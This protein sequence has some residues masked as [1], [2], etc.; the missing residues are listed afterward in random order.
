MKYKQDCLYFI[1]DRPCRFHKENP[2]IICERCKLYSP[3]NQKILIIKLAAIGDVVRTLC[4][5]KPLYKRYKN[6]RIFWITNDDAVDVLKNNPYIYEIVPYS[7][8]FYLFNQNFDILINLDLDQTAL[9]LT[10]QIFSKEKFGFYLS[11][12]DKIICSNTQAEYWFDLSHNDILKKKNRK[13][14]Q[15]CML[16]ILGFENLKL[17]DYPIILNLTEEEKKFAEDFYKKNISQAKKNLL[18]IGVNLGGGDKWRKKE[19]PIEKTIQLIKLIFKNEKKFNK[20]IKVILFGGLKER[21]RN[22]NILSELKEYVLD[23]K[24]IDAGCEN[25]LREFFSLVNLCDVFITSDSLGLHVVLG[26]NKKVLVLF[27]P[28]SPF[29]IELYGLGEKIITPLKC[30]SCYKRSCSK[31]PDCMDTILPEYIFA[32]LLKLVKK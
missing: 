5:L 19:Y 24:V 30:F 20:K 6:S 12:E 3:T 32:K 18:L 22:Q 14:Y 15:E 7:K 11:K 4:I 21:Q 1:S 2:E 16:Q 17:S 25:S 28:T 8:S 9:G 13:T 23:K 29:E 10:K 27:G 26:L 31:K